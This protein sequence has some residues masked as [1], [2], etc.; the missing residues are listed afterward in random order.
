[1]SAGRAVP[2][3][4]I[5]AVLLAGGRPRNP[6][7][8]AHMMSRAF[9]GMRKPEVAYIGT[10]NGDDP[11]F[12]TT[13]KSALTEAGAGKVVFARLAKKNADVAAAR[14]ALS[15]ADVIF[16]AGGEVENGITWLAR[17]GLTA[18][19]K[20]LYRTGKLFMGISAGVIMMG[21]RW[22]RWET[23]A[24]DSAELF[25]CLGIIPALFDVHGEDEDWD[26]L[27]TALKLMGSGA[28]GY[29]LPRECM[30]SAD[31]QGALVNLEKEYLVFVN[32]SGKVRGGIKGSTD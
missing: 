10:A 22:V 19:L 24:D 20:D 15:A 31:S 14:E 4:E 13:M 23:E 26:E 21:T 2:G 18:F 6:A 3:T 17:H 25:D 1:M 32:D 9:E 30:I 7:A 16:L 29:G 5:P 11:S 27:K 8:R 28:R 12:Y